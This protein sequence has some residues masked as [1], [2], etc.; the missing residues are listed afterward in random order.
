[1]TSTRKIRALFLLALL[2]CFPAQ[3]LAAAGTVQFAFG[4]V[5]VRDAAGKLRPLR[6][7][8]TVNEGEAIVT[9]AAGS[10]QLKMIDGGILAIRPDTELKLDTYRYAGRNDGTESALMSLVRG[11]FRTITGFIGRVNKSRY[12]IHTPTATVGIRGT[13]HEPFFIPPGTTRSGAAPGTYDK[14]NDGIAFIASAGIE[15][16]IGKN[17]MGYAAPDQRPVLLPVLPELFKATPPVQKPAAQKPAATAEE[18]QAEKPAPKA[19]EKPVETPPPPPPAP[20]APTADI[21]APPPATIL[22]PQEA[23]GQCT[24]ANGGAIECQLDFTTQTASSGGVIVPISTPLPAQQQP[25]NFDHIVIAPVAPAGSGSLMEIAT[26]AQSASYVTDAEGN[27]GS[28]ANSGSGTTLAF[29]STPVDS[30]VS[31]DVRLGRWRG[32]SYTVTGAGG[33]TQTVP[34]GAASAHWILGLE[35]PLGLVQ[36]YSGVV[37]DYS[38]LAATS[39]TDRLGNAGTLVSS[40][41][42]VDFSAQKVDS[43]INVNV[44]GRDLGASRAGMPIVGN[45]FSGSATASCTGTGCDSG[46]SASFEGAFAGAAAKKATLAYEFAGSS[47]DVV[48][49]V[50]AFQAGSI[51]DIAAAN[52]AL[53]AAQGAASAAT[54]IATTLAAAGRSTEAAQAQAWASQAGAAGAAVNAAV[55]GVFAATSTSGAQQA[56]DALD[57]ATANAITVTSQAIAA[58]QSLL[59]VAG[60]A[61]LAQSAADAALASATAAFDAFSA[62]QG[63]EANTNTAIGTLDSIATVSP[64]TPQTD[65]G[66]ASSAV[67]TATSAVG[68]AAAPAPVDLIAASSAIG[69]ATSARDAAQTAFDAL[70]SPVDT[71]PASTAIA[72]ATSAFNNTQPLLDALNVTS[73]V[74]LASATGA[75]DS[76]ASAVALAQIELDGANALAAPNVALATSNS[77]AAAAIHADVETKATAAQAAF[78][79]NGAFR[80]PIYATPANAAT[81]NAASIVHNA[82]LAAQAAAADAASFGAAFTTAKTNA[83]NSFAGANASLGAANAALATAGAENT[84]YA[85]ARSLANSAQSQASSDLAAA[86]SALGA[87]I[88]SNSAFTSDKSAAQF[89]LASAAN[90]LTSANTELANAQAANAAFSAAIA[91][92]QSALNSANASLATANTQLTALQ[93]NNTAIDAAKSAASGLPAQVSAEVSAASSAATLAQTAAVNAQSAA[94]QAAT[95]QAAGDLAG[96][97][98]QLNIALGEL[99]TATTQLTAAQSARTN[100]QSIAGNASSQL[101]AAQN[102]LAAAESAFSAAIVAAG[103]ALTQANTAQTQAGI[104]STSQTAALGAAA[105][106]LSSATGAGADASSAQNQTTNAGMNKASAQLS[107]DGA[108]SSAGSAQTNASAA[109][110]HVTSANAALTAATTAAGDAAS[111]AGL[112]QSQAGTAQTEANA[113]TSAHAAATAAVSSTTSELAAAQSAADIVEANYKQAQ[114]SNPA[115]ASLTNFL[116]LAQTVLPITGG[117]ERNWAD[118]PG[119]TG[120]YPNTNYV[121]DENKNLIEMRSTTFNTEIWN[122]QGAPIPDATVKFSGGTAQDHYH[123]ADGTVYLG[124]WR[125]GQ[126]DVTDNAALVAPFS[127]GL[128]SQSAHWIVGLSPAPSSVQNVVGS[129]AY[130]LTAATLPTDGFGNVGTLNNATFSANFTSLTADATV[131]VGFP[132]RGI[133]SLSGSATNIPITQNGFEAKTPTVVCSGAGC[134]TIAPSGWGGNIGGEFLGAATG[135]TTTGAVGTGVGLGYEF[136]PIVPS[137]S[138]APFADFIHGLAVFHTTTAPDP[139]VTAS[140]ANNSSVRHE[141]AYVTARS[142]NPNEFYILTGRNAAPGDANTNYLF[143][144]SGRLVR[145]FDTPNAIHDRSG[146]LTSTTDFAVPTPLAS[147]QVSF[148]GGLA[149]AEEAYFDAGTGIR[150]GRWQGGFVN[151]TDLLNDVGYVDALAGRSAH[152]IVYQAPTALP[153]SGTFYYT[154]LVDGSGNPSFATAPTDSYGNVGTLEGASLAVDFSRLT[155]SGGVRVSMPQGPSGSLGTARISARY[156]DAPLQSGE[157]DVASSTT[158]T[159]ES[160]FVGCAGNGCAPNQNYGGRIRGG[161]TGTNAEGAWLRYAFHTNYQDPAT[162][163]ASGRTYQEYTTGVAAFGKGP[164]IVAPSANVSLP[165]LNPPGD[166]SI[167]SAYAYTGTC[168]ASPCTQNQTAHY[169]AAGS[170]NAWVATPGYAVDGSGNLTFLSE[171]LWPDNGSSLAITGGTGATNA[172][173]NGISHGYYLQGGASPLTL[174]GTDWNGPVA[175]REPI[176]AFHWLRGPVTHPFFLA[177]AAVMPFNAVPGSSVGYAQIGG[178]VTDQDGN[179]GNVTASLGVNFNTQSVDTS[180]I[181]TLPRGT[182]N[183]AANGISLEEGSFWASNGNDPRHSFS[184]LTFNGVPTNVFGTLNGALMGQRLEGAGLAFAFQ[185]QG[186]DLATGTVVFGN[187]TYDNGATNVPFVASNLMNYRLGIGTIG[188]SAAGAVTPDGTAYTPGAQLVDEEENYRVNIVGLSSSRTQMVARDTAS[189]PAGALVK[190]D[191]SIPLVWNSCAPQGVCMNVNSAPAVFAIADSSGPG[192]TVT[193]GAIAPTARNLEFGFDPATGISWGRWGGGTMNVGDRTSA[194]HAAPLADITGP[195]SQI[196]L[197]ARNLHY[198]LTASQTGPVVLPA[199]GTFN[200]TL[201]GGTSPTAFTPGQTT[202]DVGTLSSAALTANFSTQTVNV[203][204][205]ASTPGSGNW[206]ASATNLPIL[207]GAAFFAQKALDGTGNLTVTRNG[208]P[209]NTA[210]EIVGGFAAPTG[211]GAGFAYSLNHNGPIGST[212]SGVAVFKRP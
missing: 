199:S 77:T 163:A 51:P 5:Q 71:A 188:M 120:I 81:Q 87:A 176:G 78:T 194:N 191:G 143:D 116:H 92:A 33:T 29:A 211:K 22:Q 19:E 72:N 189:N 135:G 190:F 180:V 201:A 47:A 146:Q 56:L 212:I 49:G 31:P 14:V 62:A 169:E 166:A 93:N 42:V 44:A 108:L 55:S 88:S 43:V 165:A 178:F 99:S 172:S 115:V 130:A 95:L 86:N 91:A 125:G 200:Y 23:S 185:S 139:G 141:L 177:D 196:D 27:V 184:S 38:V 118:T 85:N 103:N 70:G 209:A 4:E 208:S 52:S 129:R 155:T 113:A 149:S 157:I 75:R 20:Q 90:G 106:A 13:D 54:E 158:P 28:F 65:I 59:S 24:D 173:A 37:S 30:F 66:S 2:A 39:P 94:T 61:P 144:A 171:N 204:V 142:A 137:A 210:G 100:A 140:F 35:P 197:T 170:A 67:A 50:V 202:L 121:L 168:G 124:R 36:R 83:N 45:Y 136:L 133:S 97:Q 10:A 161:F 98:A 187:P 138:P 160:L 58:A 8:E 148:G 64:V 147:A 9:G 63:F 89:F 105:N 203:S 57:V 110:G 7:G 73:A 84:N 117:V 114:Y 134:A 132:T 80:D 186:S 206:A 111:Q 15:Q 40:S 104:A 69:T 102:A 101:T 127:L 11:G 34:L 128:G 167:L 181:A 179:P 6:K 12:T 162:A 25:N 48:Q 193:N 53:L 164:E 151:V 16:N 182:F 68:S 82:D 192:P 123:A 207:A 109:A 32:G 21:I 159:L 156:S 175:N 46:Y 3:A 205:A 150:L 18:K 79:A 183:A 119:E 152:W 126:M 74:S 145:V 1:M 17:Q 195:V 60:P 131:D 174:N 41:F 153:A 107:V 112:A 198:L 154:R 96:A 76:A 26:G 122:Q